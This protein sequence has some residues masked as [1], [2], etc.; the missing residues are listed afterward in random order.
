[1]D[2]PLD[3]KFSRDGKAFIAGNQLGT[4]SLF[5]CETV[6]HQYEATRV[7]Q[8]FLFDGSRD[9]NN[10]FER[11]E[12]KPQICGYNMIPYEVQ[13]TRSLI[14]RFTQAQPLQESQQVA[15]TNDKEMDTE[16]VQE[17]SK[18][19]QEVEQSRIFERKLILAKELGMMEEK[20]YKDQIDER[21][22]ESN[23][24]QPFVLE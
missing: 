18:F 2:N 16:D 1:M 10:P 17:E 20:Y 3:G 11:V 4:I 24:Y 12:N 7:Q 15:L 9:T 13:P 6:A 23:L 5:S 22:R 19:D 8:F 14:G 21:R